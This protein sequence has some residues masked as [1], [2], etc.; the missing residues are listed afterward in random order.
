MFGIKA[1]DEM[2]LYDFKRLILTNQKTK[3]QPFFLENDIPNT[4]TLKDLYMTCDVLKISFD[5][6]NW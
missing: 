1:S 4:S 5:L 3:Q 2:K 6:N